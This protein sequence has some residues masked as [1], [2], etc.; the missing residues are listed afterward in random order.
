MCCKTPRPFIVNNCCK[1][2]ASSW[3]HGYEYTM[4]PRSLIAAFPKNKCVQTSVGIYSFLYGYSYRYLDIIFIKQML[5]NI[6]L[7]SWLIKLKMFDFFD[8]SF[9]FKQLINNNITTI[10]FHMFFYFK[11]TNETIQVN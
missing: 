1:S 9:A 10:F 5:R 8:T 2:S 3:D 4:A 7:L 6:E 11:L